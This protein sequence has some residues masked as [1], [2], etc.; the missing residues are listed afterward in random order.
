M[1]YVFTAVFEKRGRWYIGYVEELPGA[2]AQGRTLKE[3]KRNLKE[4]VELILETNRIVV[5]S[6]IMSNKIIRIP[7]KVAA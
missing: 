7:F 3:V 6:E 2:N 5:S 1:S 4:A